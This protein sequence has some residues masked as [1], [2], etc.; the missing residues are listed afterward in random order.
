MPSATDELR[1]LVDEGRI[2]A[3]KWLV[4]ALE[5]AG[6]P[7]P[8]A[9][10]QRWMAV[11]AVL[12]ASGKPITKKTTLH[13]GATVTVRPQPAP[14]SEARP[15][16]SVTFDVIFE[17]QHL[18]VVD[19]P[20]GLVVHPAK[21][22][23]TGTLVNGLL[24][25]GDFAVEGDPR[26]PEGH[27]RP[28]IVHRLDKDTSGLLVVA[29]TAPCRE[30][31]KALFQAH[32]IARA[33]IAL[34]EGEAQSRHYATWHGRDPR[35]R[36]RY[37]SRFP[38]EKPGLR[39]AVTDVEVRERGA[40]ATMVWCTLETGRTHQIRVHLSEAGTPILGDQLYGRDPAEPRLRDLSRS[41]SRH[42]LHA[43]VLG[44][45]HPITGV[46]HLWKTPLPPELQDLWIALT[47]A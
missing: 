21:G 37:T 2:R 7:T 47:N 38:A 43:A 46:K 9:E 10:I 15:D 23:P 6:R 30:G 8:R 36:I 44:F 27:L 3:D 42:A 39:R 14:L 22:H 35:H 40:S 31:L 32:D 19:K 29:K 41:L 4:A 13:R 20:A 18:L 33:Y 17:D 16:P 28:G 5:A 1:L 45:V 12:D 24:A 25:R 26:D 34:V 11:G